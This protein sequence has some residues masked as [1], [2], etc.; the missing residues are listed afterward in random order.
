MADRCM[1][2]GVGVPSR[3]FSRSVGCISVEGGDVVCGR[4]F[5]GEVV[6]VVP[7]SMGSGW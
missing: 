5:T 2:L 3:I 4:G 7:L 6:I 1:W